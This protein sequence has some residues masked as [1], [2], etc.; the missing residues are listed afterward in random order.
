MRKFLFVIGWLPILPFALQAQNNQVIATPGKSGMIVKWFP[1]TVYVAEGVDVYRRPAG[2]VQ[3]EK[4]TTK[5]LKKGDIPLPQEA[6]VANPT[7]A[8]YRDLADKLTAKDL[9][10]LAGA[11]LT[12]QSVLSPDFARYLGNQ[13]TDASAVAG[14]RYEYRVVSTSGKELKTSP[15]VEMGGEILELSPSVIVHDLTDTRFQVAWKE[16]PLRFLGVNIYRSSVVEGRKKLNELPLMSAIANPTADGSPKQGLYADTTLQYGV[17]YAYEVVGIDFFGRETQPSAAIEVRAED[18]TPPLPVSAL[19]SQADPKT[20]LI[21]LRW[22]RSP[23]ADAAG[24]DIYRR[25]RKETG[26]FK[27]VNVTLKQPSDTVFIDEPPAADVWFYKVATLDRAGNSRDS[28]TTFAMLPDKE[29]PAAPQGLILEA[30]S[31]E[32]H[33][34]WQ[35][36]TEPDLLGYRLYR[37]I[38]ENRSESFT[39]IHNEVLTGTSYIDKL[40]AVARNKFIYRLIALDSSGNE[41]KGSLAAEGRMPDV[42]APEQPVL[43]A[44][45]ANADKSITITWLANVD[46]DLK[47]YQLFRAV[48]SLAYT[49]VGSLLAPNQ[50]VFTD[51]GL[52]E[53]KLYSYSL[54]AIDS[55]NNISEQSRPLSVRL[56]VSLTP[57]AIKVTNV[58]MAYDKRNKQL[59]LTWNKPKSIDLRGFVVY[60]KLENSNW[61]PVS[62]MLSETKFLDADVKPGQ[63][64]YYEV[65]TYADGI[66]AVS[67][68]FKTT[69]N[70]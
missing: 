59:S 26:G 14:Q 36:N 54:T 24:Y 66:V 5:P 45:K 6:V 29:P 50:T 34:K 4:L 7:L 42:I 57:D 11:F 43:T 69:I 35:P 30:K 27:K 68:P 15:A 61:K 63:T 53:G 62:G 56:T 13:Y 39:L 64:Y 48:D 22:N 46:S 3:W 23:S 32:M 47:G 51:K 2:A 20:G 44:V 18:R 65:R 70:E 49:P 12:I 40:P 19:S 31:G 67:Q 52:S 58:S 1:E 9:N 17:S 10:S 16:E 41:S 21:A 60:R 55:S 33:L 8:S 38:N 28:D 25:G 37:T